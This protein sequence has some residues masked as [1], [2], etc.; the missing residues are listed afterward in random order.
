MEGSL[1]IGRIFG[2][3]IGLHYSWF[4]IFGLVT[5]SL[6]AGLLPAEYPELGTEVYWLL[7]LITSLLFFGSVLV[8]ELAHA[9]VARLHQVPVSGI[10]LFIFGGTAEMTREPRSAVAE[11]RI[12]AAGPI[13]S[14]ILSIFF[15]GLWLLDQHISYLAAPSIWLARINLMLAAF[16]LIP[17][18]PLD[19]G[20]ILRAFIWWKTGNLYRATKIATYSGQFTAFG[21][22]GLGI[23]T[24]ITGGFFSGLWL[25]FIGWFLQNAAVASYADSALRNSLVGVRVEQAMSREVTLVPPL[26]P[27]S[28][29]VE[30]RVLPGGEQY[31]FVGENDQP[32]GLITLAD[33]L[34][35]P[36]RKWRF[37]TAQQLMAPLGR[38]RTVEP[39]DEMTLALELM[40][41]GK[42]NHV[43]VVKDGQVVGLVSRTQIAN[44]V[45]LKAELGV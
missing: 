16:N 33:I 36:E 22:V 26:T 24:M 12:S 5:W 7:G 18:F 39:E 38:L 29:L 10:N 30:E 28:R 4:F 1:K 35:L 34:S 25:V 27:V 23:A 40:E 6:A 44:Y 32:Q 2:I 41:D 3:P 9:V 43:P 21:F 45:R 37:L 19:G 42:T 11:F 8:H 31:F 14:F 20:R 17:G 15:F 13:A